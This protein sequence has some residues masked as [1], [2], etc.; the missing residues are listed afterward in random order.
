MKFRLVRQLLPLTLMVFP[1]EHSL[2]QKIR[3]VRDD[4]GNSLIL[5]GGFRGGAEHPQAYVTKVDDSHELRISAPTKKR[6][7]QEIER[8]VKE[9]KL[10]AG[11]KAEIL[12]SITREKALTWIEV[13]EASSVGS[14]AA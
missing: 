14:D 3:R 13:E 9:G 1:S 6:L 4:D 10:P 2:G 8:L 11:Q 12:E 5:K 7:A